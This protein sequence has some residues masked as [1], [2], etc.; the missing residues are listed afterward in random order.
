[1]TNQ[2][3]DVAIIGAGPGGLSA[4]ARSAQQ[5]VSHILLEASVR[6][7]NTIQDYQMGKHVMAEPCVLPLRSDIDFEAGTQETILGK[8]EKSIE[9][10]Q[11]N[12]HYQT[13]VKSITGNKG[14]FQI[15][16]R[17]GDSI[18]AK[19]IVLAMG[20]QGN[21]RK[22]GVKGEDLPFV[23][24]NLKSAD[25][26]QNKIIV[27]IGAGDSA[28]EDAIVLA[29]HN[30]VIIVNRG[31]EFSRAKERNALLIQRAIE[32]TQVECY[33]NTTVN[34]IEAC[35]SDLPAQ[36]YLDTPEGQVSI[37]CNLIIMRLG[38]IPLRTFMKSIG[39]RFVSDDI[40]A[41]PELSDYYESSVPGLY[42]IGSLGGYPLIKNALNQ[43]Y[44]VIE[45]LLGNPIEPADQ[46]I[47]KKKLQILPFTGDVN[48][49]LK[50]I[51]QE[52]RLFRNISTLNLR[53]LVLDSQVRVINKGLKIFDQGDHSSTF[54]NIIQGEVKAHM[55]QDQIE[56]VKKGEFFGEM[57]VISG[58]PRAITAVTS[59]KCF[60][61]ETPRK[62][63]LNLLR[64]ENSVRESIDKVTIFRTLHHT[65]APNAPIDTIRD[66][67]KNAVLR[68]FASNDVLYSEG[69][70]AD[71][72]YL[73]R[74]GSLTLSRNIA[75][76]DRIVAYRAAGEYAG[77]MGLS[78]DALYMDTA[79]AT[80]ATVAIGISLTSFNKLLMADQDLH[81]QIRQQIEKSLTQYIRMQV[82]PQS[83]EILSFMMSQGLGEA[84]DVLIIDESICI[85]CD[86][87]EKACAATHSG[88]SRLDRK[89][90]PTFASLHIPSACRHCEHPHCM[91]D[92]PPD[93]IHRSSSGGV[94]IDDSCIGC[95][96]C[97]QNCPYD[98]IQM[99]EVTNKRS[100]WDNFFGKPIEAVGKTAVKCDMCK[101]EKTGSACV[102]SCPTG[103]AIRVHAE[104]LVDIAKKKIP[105]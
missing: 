27:V 100:L 18:H 44:E 50:Q 73:L 58:R 38:T 24:N 10:A 11:I 81:S 82:Q 46:P 29:C 25:T 31:E 78:G 45:H 36:I 40:D 68:K 13:V 75:N 12:I 39:I 65:M 98:V 28:I 76:E 92:C 84:T 57:S 16:L 37:T 63:F 97:V 21:T 86:N 14:E 34:R 43:G 47:I 23:Q 56:T 80:V 90:G 51:K 42:I 87:C 52:V 105:S 95:G 61:L 1:M 96:N 33:Y 4:A 49:I 66:I 79:T 99:A 22:L 9:Q 93:A 20:T 91:Q 19:N 35:N 54:F 8:W 77:L 15:F 60:L 67:A 48:N 53:E 30:R 89:A 59:T 7:A 64:K 72:V 101:D 104:Q 71:T 32:N 74:S 94:Y 85:G 26:F 70:P 102:N 69:D 5:N 62:A 17:N 103:A 41:I 2:F 6:H 3:Y 55:T 88:I 83:S